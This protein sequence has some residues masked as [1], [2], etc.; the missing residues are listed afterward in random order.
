M[1]KKFLQITDITAYKTAFALSNY[2][3]KIIIRWDYFSKDTIGKQFMRAADSI[4]SNIAEGFGKYT[5]KDKIHFYHY[6]YGSVKELFDWNEK[7]KIRNLLTNEEYENI[8]NELN[9][10]PKEINGLIKFTNYK[11]T[12]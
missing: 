9:K 10:L 8:S 4:S 3:W 12:I 11:L 1:D 6:S 7:A 2:I 5:K